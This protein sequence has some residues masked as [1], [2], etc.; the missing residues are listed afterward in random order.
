M[1]AIRIESEIRFETK[2]TLQAGLEY[3]EFFEYFDD[4]FIEMIAE[5]LDVD[6][7]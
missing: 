4:E 3:Q 1:E 5:Q 7:S 6:Q 2:L